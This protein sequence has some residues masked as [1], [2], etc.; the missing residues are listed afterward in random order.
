MARWLVYSQTMP[1]WRWLLIEGEATVLRAL[2]KLRAARR[3]K[4]LPIDVAMFAY[5]PVL[6]A[7]Q[8]T[9]TLPLA[10]EILYWNRSRLPALVEKQVPSLVDALRKNPAVDLKRYLTL[11]NSIIL[12]GSQSS[13]FLLGLT[14]TVSII[15]GPPGYVCQLFD[16]IVD[17]PAL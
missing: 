5:E 13:S 11:P 12:D 8:D 6:K 1:W 2:P 9:L 3:I 17:S 10:S 16:I 14:Q 4:L 15:Q 7:M